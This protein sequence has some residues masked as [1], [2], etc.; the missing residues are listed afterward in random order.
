MALGGIENLNVR[1]D[2]EPGGD[3]RVIKQ[4]HAIFGADPVESQDRQVADSEMVIANAD[5]VVPAIADRAGPD[6]RQV[7]EPA[8]RIRVPVGPS[9]AAGEGPGGIG[10]RTSAS[11]ART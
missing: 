7:G 5:R 11:T 10:S 2:V 8:D 6:Q 3:G 9:P 4:F 1:R